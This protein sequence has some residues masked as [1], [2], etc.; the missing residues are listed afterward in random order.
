V[1]QVA[2]L[3]STA[4]HYRQSPAL[5][6]PWG[7]HGIQALRGVLQSLLESQNSVQI[8][9]EHHLRGQ[10]SRWP[11]IVI[12]EWDFLDTAFRDEL[13][14]YV[15]DGGSLLLVSHR[16]ARLFASEL[17]VELDGDPTTVGRYLEHQGWLAGL[18]T[19]VQRVKPGPRARTL[20]KLHREDDPGS[21]WDVAATL[22]AWGQGKVG[23]LW[24]DY[25]DA[26]LNRRVPLARDFLE[27][28]V[29]A[30]FPEPLVEVQGTHQVDVSVAR[31]AGRLVVHF[32]NTAGPHE[33]AQQYVFDD[34]PAAGPLQVEVRLP[35]KPRSVTLEPGGRVQR[36]GYRDGR[37]LVTLP[38]VEIHDMLVVEPAPAR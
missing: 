21:P 38:P 35:A 11:L 4:A 2:L 32:V 15:K 12:P 26:Y 9:S 22:A 13:A 14:A 30:L 5:F 24:F 20:G 23:A 29:R 27:A 34:I 17:D 16:A 19:S 3:Y 36:F 33:Q 10:M 25:G 18:N 31:Q 28:A 37:L 1:P 6:G 8:V 7:T